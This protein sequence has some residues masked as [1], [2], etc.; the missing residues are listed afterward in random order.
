[1]EILLRYSVKNLLE[2][3]NKYGMIR[4]IIGEGNKWLGLG[5]LTC[6]M[7]IISLFFCLFKSNFF[8][9]NKPV[10]FIPIS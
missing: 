8:A 4:R 9:N 5:E 2:I 7:L 10:H 3:K 6:Y 1:V